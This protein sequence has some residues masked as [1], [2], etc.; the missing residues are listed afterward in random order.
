[1]HVGSF[2]VRLLSS[3]V[4]K[5][6]FFQ[7]FISRALSECHEIWIHIRTN[8]SHS[9]GPDLDSKCLQ[10]QPTDDK[11]LAT[12]KERAKTLWLNLHA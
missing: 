1:M 8:K 4:F 6:N 12:S 9:V 3:A 11:S 5:I 2:F 7:K 10:R